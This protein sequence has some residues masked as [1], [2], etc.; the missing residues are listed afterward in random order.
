MSGEKK[1]REEME[2]D[3][4]GGE[5]PPSTPAGAVGTGGWVENGT[6]KDREI[7]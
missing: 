4:E 6:V 7:R 2:G 5:G 1:T 3:R